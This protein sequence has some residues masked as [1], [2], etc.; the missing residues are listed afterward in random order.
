VGGKN[1]L[2]TTE[3]RKTA[4]RRVTPKRRSR[5]TETEKGV[6]SKGGYAGYTLTRII[7]TEKRRGKPVMKYLT[8]DELSLYLKISKPTI[9]QWIAKNTIPYIRI[10]QRVIRFDVEKIDAFMRENQN[11]VA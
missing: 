3:N 9:Y 6:K 8:I 5:K 2:Y 1:T 10:N 7:T 4:K 11:K